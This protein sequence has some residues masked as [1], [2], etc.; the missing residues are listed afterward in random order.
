M[1]PHGGEDFANPVR[2]GLTTD[3]IINELSVLIPPNLYHKNPVDSWTR[4]NPQPGMRMP[5]DDK[6]LFKAVDVCS[7]RRQV[8]T[9]LEVFGNMPK[10]NNVLV[11]SNGEDRWRFRN[12]NDKET[13]IEVQREDWFRVLHRRNA[14]AMGPEDTGDS[15]S[16][17]NLPELS[18]R[19]L[20]VLADRAV[21]RSSRLDK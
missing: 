6:S 1:E 15:F 13:F 2:G 20:T 19:A 14:N 7:S 3:N 12:V 16:A 8:R 5:Q 10:G 21:H 18:E 4:M 11:K 9:P 17:E